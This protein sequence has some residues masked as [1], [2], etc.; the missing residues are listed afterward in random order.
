MFMA[1]MFVIHSI[2]CFY[3]DMNILNMVTLTQDKLVIQLRYV[4]LDPEAFHNQALCTPRDLT[5]RT[6]LELRCEH[7]RDIE[8]VTMGQCSRGSRPLIP[9]YACE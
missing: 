2:A 1:L 9:I 5:A 6:T 4:E 3:N 8:S 7:D